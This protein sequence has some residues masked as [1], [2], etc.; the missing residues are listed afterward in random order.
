MTQTAVVAAAIVAI[1]STTA[2]GSPGH[3]DA[4]TFGSPGGDENVSRTIEVRMGEMYFEPS[5]ITVEPGETIRFVVINEGEA[6]HEFNLGTSQTWESHAGEMNRMMDEGMIDYDSI[7]HAKMREM[8]MMHS[9]PNA[10]LLEPGDRAEVIWKFPDNVA[11]VGMAC[12][13]PG[14]RE[15][16]MVGQFQWES[17]S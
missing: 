15:S 4:A 13:V 5:D 16:G 14:H 11:E 3:G 17:E 10:V 2:L 12:N 9:D 6:V 7:D 1:T 8:G